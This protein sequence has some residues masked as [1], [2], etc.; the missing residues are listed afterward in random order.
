MTAALPIRV[1]LLEDDALDADLI[2]ESLAKSDLT[3]EIDRVWERADFIKATNRGIYDIVLADYTLPAFDGLSAMRIWQQKFP[4]IPFIIV[5]ATLE[6]DAATNAMRLGASDFVVKGRLSRLPMVISRALAEA[7]EKSRRQQAERRLEDVNA[8]LELLVD[9][10]TRE[11]D[12]IWTVSQDLFAVFDLRGRILSANPAWKT[13]LGLSPTL[14]EGKQE[15]ELKHPDHRGNS[16]VVVANS[17]SDDGV[18]ELEERLRHSDGTYRWISWRVGAPENER[19][20]AVGRDIT[21]AKQQAETLASAEE[22]LRQAQKMEAIGQLTGGVAHDFNNLLTIIVGNLESLQRQHAGALSEKGRLA[23]ESAMRGAQ[24]AAKLTSSLLAFARRQAL[25]PRQI[26]AN[27][28]VLGMAD[29]LAKATSESVVL[30]YRYADDLWWTQ[31]DTNQLENA[32]LNLA[33]NARDAM[34]E[35]GEIVISTENVTLDAKFCRDADVEPGE[36]VK[37]SVADNGPGMDKATLQQAFDPFF[38]T[39]DFGQ[40]TG[41][42]LSQVYGFVKQSGGHVSIHSA[43]N[44][45]TTVALFLP[46]LAEVAVVTSKPAAEPDTPARGSETILLVEDEAEVRNYTKG[47]LEELGYQVIEAEDGPA[48][49]NIAAGQSSF[50][51][52]LSD[53]GLPNGM[54]GRELADEM[55]KARPDLKVMFVSGYASDA[56]VREGK[57]DAGVN[58]LRKP[59]TFA[60]LA[61][62]LREVLGKEQRQHRILFVEDEALIRIIM[63]EALA[64]QGFLIEEAGSATEAMER[65]HVLDGQLD[66]VVLDLGLPDRS[67][68]FLA[69]E[70]RDLRPDLPIVVA[71]G[72]S[73]SQMRSRFLDTERMAFVGKPYDTEALV[74]ALKTLWAGGH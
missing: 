32:I 61:E 56:V 20:F 55:R 66:G 24:R 28:L 15:A 29:L 57:L 51:L 59:F 7:E 39:K 35:G 42:G 27:D 60:A 14:V 54:N 38:T 41:L 30:N 34:T 52:L 43:L 19:I 46:R 65:L 53:I 64:D 18:S 4:T 12:R 5:S 70:I 17:Q 62:R 48:A 74:Q 9:A 44:K 25:T 13:V 26:Q 33:V 16:I 63:A 47:I 49:L 72:H 11:R 1:L 50:D 2:G 23:V 71:S 37:I 68:D 69:S 22:Q 73:E 36:Y 40:G 58:L 8:G 21:F 67:G 31:A 3:V 45:G 10:R 6:E